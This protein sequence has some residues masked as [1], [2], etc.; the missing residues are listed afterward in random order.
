[1]KIGMYLAALGLA[2]GAVSAQGAIV[3]NDGTT[4]S[5]LTTVVT[6]TRGDVDPYTHT[7]TLAVDGGVLDATVGESANVSDASAKGVWYYNQTAVT[8]DSYSVSADFKPA[9]SNGRYRGGVIGWYD[10]DSQTGIALYVKPG[11]DFRVRSMKMD[12]PLDADNEDSGNFLLNADGS[13]IGGSGFNFGLG[14]YDINEF[15]TFELVFSAPTVGGATAMVTANVY[16]D[17]MLLNSQDFA[18]SLPAPSDH[19]VGYIA[20]LGSSNLVEEVGSLDNLTFVPEPASLALAA[21]GGLMLIARR[22]SA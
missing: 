20:Y 13:S 4:T 15:A 2:L 12:E 10:A 1:M 16:Q 14:S 21:M 18:I 11:S 7:A 6:P 22:R 17:N 8:T 9:G 5:D 3:L 19:R